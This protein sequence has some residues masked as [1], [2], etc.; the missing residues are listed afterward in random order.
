MA[1]PSP[2]SCACFVAS[3]LAGGTDR[4]L[5][6]NWLKGQYH[7]RAWDVNAS[8]F[9]NEF[10]V[11]DPLGNVSGRRT[12]VIALDPAAET[13]RL[14]V[15]TSAGN[16]NSSPIAMPTVNYSHFDFSRLGSFV[17][18]NGVAIFNTFNIVIPEPPSM[19]LA[20]LALLALSG[21]SRRSR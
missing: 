10:F 18:A 15:E 16:L 2:S 4:W 12:L 11:D 19:M 1:A 13:A 5:E 21:R 17:D 8:N 6:I 3:Y 20:G 9:F 14:T 7:F